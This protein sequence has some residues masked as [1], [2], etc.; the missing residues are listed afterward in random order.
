MNM[1]VKVS[2]SELAQKQFIIFIT[3][4]RVPVR[5]RYQ[6]QNL[7]LQMFFKSARIVQCSMYILETFDNKI[8]VT[9]SKVQLKNLSTFFT[10]PWPPAGDFI[11]RPPY[12]LYQISL[13]PE[14]PPPPWPPASYW[15]KAPRYHLNLILQAL[16]HSPPPPHSGAGEGWGTGGFLRE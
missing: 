7:P 1:E 13:S 12:R 14:P 4:W 3:T 5:C 15:S 10:D 11:P 2:V 9:F 16:Q 6:N 8:A